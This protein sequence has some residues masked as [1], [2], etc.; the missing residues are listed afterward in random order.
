MKK[1]KKQLCSLSADN[2]TGS[3]KL[4]LI[5]TGIQKLKSIYSLVKKH[6]HRS[7]LTITEQMIRNCPFVIAESYEGITEEDIKYLENELEKYKQS[8]RE[9]QN[10]EHSFHTEQY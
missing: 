7:P 6:V 10:S 2:L 3:K 9:K 1:R 5:D 8:I 4:S